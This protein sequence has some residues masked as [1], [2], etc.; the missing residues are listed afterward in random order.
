MKK[1]VAAAA[2]AGDTAK[3]RALGST[4]FYNWS[5]SRSSAPGLDYVPMVWGEAGPPTPHVWRRSRR[6]RKPVGSVLLL[7]VR[8]VADL[9]CLD[10]PRLQ[11]VIGP[12]LGHR[13]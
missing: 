2:Y 11:V 5:D 1:G 8:V 7:T 4:W 9:E 13:V 12:D 6:G 10:S 3:L